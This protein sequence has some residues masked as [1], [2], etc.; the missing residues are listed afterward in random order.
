MKGSAVRIRA[1]APQ[2]GPS[3]RAFLLPEASDG[4]RQIGGL[5]TNC[6]RADSSSATVYSEPVAAELNLPDFEDAFDSFRLAHQTLNNALNI[7]QFLPDAVNQEVAI[8]GWD[9]RDSW[10]LLLETAPPSDKH[11]LSKATI[12]RTCMVEIGDD[13]GTTDFDLS[14]TQKQSLLDSGHAAAQSFLD[15][16]R[17]EDYIN[18]HG[19]RLAAA[20]AVK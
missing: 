18:R 9:I 4:E 5:Q 1:S 8:L 17:P 11:F 19:Q 7:S 3:V 16:Y 12:V 14:A 13:I 2:K 15:T 20:V 6:K 10:P